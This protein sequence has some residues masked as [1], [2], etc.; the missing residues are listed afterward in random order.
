MLALH[1]LLTV[2]SQPIATAIRPMLNRITYFGPKR[3]IRKPLNSVVLAAA[4]AKGMKILADTAA[5]RLRSARID[6]W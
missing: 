2:S 5:L 6:A 3:S 4:M 1:A